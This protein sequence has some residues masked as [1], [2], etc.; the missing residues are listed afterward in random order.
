MRPCS[1]TAPSLATARRELGGAGTSQAALAIGG[2]TPP[3]FSAAT[4]EF[5]GEILTDN[6][7]TVTTS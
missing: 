7:K 5:T 3:T 1:A 2:Y 4:E 6:V